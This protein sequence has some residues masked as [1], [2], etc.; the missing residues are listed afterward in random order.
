MTTSKVNGVDR[1]N[2]WVVEQGT[3]M[4]TPFVT[5]TVGLWLEADPD[6]TVG[7]ARSIMES[8]ATTTGVTSD[9]WWGAGKI[10]ALRGIKEVIATKGTGG[11]DNIESD[12][13]SRLKVITT[14]GRLFTIFFDQADGFTATLYS[15]S[16]GAVKLVVT[17]S[18]SAELDA[19]SLTGGIYLL[20]VNGKSG[21]ATRKLTVR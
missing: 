2:Y 9:V 14:D 19:S 3:S 15:L 1:Q 7:K 5:G 6:L 11:V 16:G 8:T 13:E 17:G 20:E 4:A 10:N 21:R 18:E 12:A